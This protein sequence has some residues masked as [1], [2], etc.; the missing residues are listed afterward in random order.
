MK[1]RY[2]ATV[3]FTKV[4]DNLSKRV[5]SSALRELFDHFGRVTDVCVAYFNPR[6]NVSTAKYVSKSDIFSGRRSRGVRNV[7]V[8]ETLIGNGLFGAHKQKLP[9]SSNP[10]PKVFSG[11]L[12]DSRSYIIGANPLP[13]VDERGRVSGDKANRSTGQEQCSQDID[14]LKRRL[15]GNVKKVYSLEMVQK[16]LLSENIKCKVCPWGGPSSILA[17]DSSNDLEDNKIQRCLLVD[18]PLR[19]WNESFF[20]SL[21][22]QREHF[23]SLDPDTRDR[24]RLNVAKMVVKVVSK[25]CIPHHAYVVSKGTQLSKDEADPRHRY[26]LVVYC[27]I[28]MHA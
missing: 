28:D 18:V 14:W 26:I 4:V 8:S 20:R 27:H 15:I 12:R 10:R 13:M 9:K 2:S 16:A 23:V 25:A 24:N 19:C 5:P 7:T 17:I 21:G 1:S 11:A 3:S 22:D 6:R